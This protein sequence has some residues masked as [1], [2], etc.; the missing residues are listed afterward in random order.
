MKKPSK[1]YTSSVK[2]YEPNYIMKAGVRVWH[3]MFS[4]IIEFRGL[5]WRLIIRDLSA[6]Y[7]QSI[8]GILWA[9]IAP[10]TT[11]LIFVWIKSKNI[12][13]IRET[14]M[15]YAAFVFIGQM[16]W[17]LFSQG[18]LLSAN[19]LVAAGNMLTKINFPREILVFSAV[20]Q[21]IF[22][23][24]IRA[25][26]LCGVFASVG[27]LPKLSILFTPFILLPLLLLVIGIG[28]FLSIF[29]AL[30]RDTNNALGIILN[31][32]MFLT[33][34]IYPPPTTWPL[35]FLINTVNPISSII[36]AIRDLTISGHILDPANYIISVILSIL[37][38]SIGWRFFHLTEPKI[39]EKV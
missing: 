4:E 34:V 35:S 25:V 3:D 32:G 10:L 16:V 26:L 29:N 5:I 27:F 31:M 19:S 17:L 22:D 8:F 24:F 6:R 1:K 14:A 9:F 28:F 18:I 15:P 12:L 13:P 23:F 38:F 30:T 33:P 7:K 37:I 21:T 36:T 2:I 20:G 11:M 39:A